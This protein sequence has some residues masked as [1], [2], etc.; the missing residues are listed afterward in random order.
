MV[1]MTPDVQRAPEPLRGS[2]EPRAYA[3][4]IDCCERRAQPESAPPRGGAA[5]QAQAWEHTRRSHT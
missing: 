5:E 4:R 3:R 2:P 1:A